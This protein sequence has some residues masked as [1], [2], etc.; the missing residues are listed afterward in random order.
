MMVQRLETVY[1]KYDAS[2]FKEEVMKI[3]IEEQKAMIV[4]MESN[5]QMSAKVKLVKI[6]QS[7]DQRMTN[8]KKRQERSE[9]SR[10]AL[11]K[12]SG[13]PGKE[14]G[15]TSNKKRQRE[16]AAL[17]QNRCKGRSPKT[18]HHH[19]ICIVLLF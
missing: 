14:E 1:N 11:T 8:L 15:A 7:F 17:Q 2:K 19:C 16:D 10:S 5:D 6:K 3:T 12:S 4:V 9:N 18:N 13:A